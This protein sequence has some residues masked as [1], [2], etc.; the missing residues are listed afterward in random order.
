MGYRHKREDVLD[1]AVAVAKDGGL[2]QLSFRTTGRRLGIADRT[3][4]YYF[5]TKTHLVEA[6]LHRSTQRLVSVLAA[7]VGP[8]P[9]QRRQL[10]EE[11]WTALR[12]PEADPWLRLYVETLGL[13]VRGVQP[14][15][16]ITVELAQSWTSWFADRLLPEPLDGPDDLTDQA[17]GLLA[18]LDGL[19][20][21]HTAVGPDLATRASRGLGLP[22]A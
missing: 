19:L 15:A 21:L 12:Q 10:L 5:P 8:E 14:Y 16:S 17:A 20:L 2:G 13:A 18:S 22:P 9:R 1:A 4:V 7:A 3:V 6:V 11:A